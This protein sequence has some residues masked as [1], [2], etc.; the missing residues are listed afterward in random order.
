MVVKGQGEEQD[1]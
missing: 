1:M